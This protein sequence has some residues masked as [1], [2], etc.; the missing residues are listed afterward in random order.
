MN[1]HRLVNGPFSH[2]TLMMEV[3]T[4]LLPQQLLVPHCNAV[5]NVLAGGG[6]HAGLL[7]L[8]VH[9]VLETNFAEC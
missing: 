3:A 2:L 5:Y 9:Y 4:G 6:K 7:S 8:I 1:L